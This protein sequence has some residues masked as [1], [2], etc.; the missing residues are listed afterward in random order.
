MNSG[1][2]I[3]NKNLIEWIFYTENF[4]KTVDKILNYFEDVSLVEYFDNSFKLKIK[5]NSDIKRDPTNGF[6]FTFID[7]IKP[8]CFI[9][10][11]SINQSSLEQIFNKFA[12]E[13]G[14]EV[15]Q[16]NNKKEMKLTKEII[17][18]LNLR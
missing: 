14:E 3:T 10:E 18:S 16:G 8:D 17:Q 5:K 15:L 6:L 13:V 9:S 2:S 4:L 7:D 11:Y 1:V 12:K